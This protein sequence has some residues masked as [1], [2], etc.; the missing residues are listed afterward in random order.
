MP[1]RNASA[2]D[3]VNGLPLPEADRALFVA[4]IAV[5]DAVCYIFGYAGVILFCT[6]AAPALLKIDLRAEA[7]KLEQALGMNRAK[8]G[9]ASA[10]GRT[11]C[12]T[13]LLWRDW[14]LPMQRHG[15]PSIGCL[16]TGFGVKD[17]FLRQN[18]P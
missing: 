10:C 9:V 18:P 3:A 2:T 11:D 5:A 16:F 4:H 12:L 7:L 8:P 6:V 1:S 17:G 13:G 14:R 15:C